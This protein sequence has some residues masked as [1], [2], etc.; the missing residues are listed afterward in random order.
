MS[1][2]DKNRDGILGTYKE[3]ITVNE[4]LNDLTFLALEEYMAKTFNQNQVQLD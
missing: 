2:L 1:L 4:G 3:G